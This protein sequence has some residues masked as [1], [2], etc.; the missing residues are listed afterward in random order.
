MKK[1]DKWSKTKR[2][3][4]QQTTW[5]QDTEDFVNTRMKKILDN[6]VFNLKIN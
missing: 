1:E 3:K 2:R 6:V 4:N 5:S